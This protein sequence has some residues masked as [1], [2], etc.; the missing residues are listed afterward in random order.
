MYDLSIILDRSSK[1]R[2]S[3]VGFKYWL[4]TLLTIWIVQY[5]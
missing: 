2:L 1:P 3:G 5:Y 4:F